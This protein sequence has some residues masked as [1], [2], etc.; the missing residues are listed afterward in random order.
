MFDIISWIAPLLNLVGLYL[1]VL[2]KKKL[3]L[4]SQ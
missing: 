3:L 4:Y 1:A 2:K